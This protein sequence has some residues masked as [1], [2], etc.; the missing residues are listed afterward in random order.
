MLAVEFEKREGSLLTI[1]QKSRELIDI[2][3]SLVSLLVNDFLAA[4]LLDRN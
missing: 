1:W 4:D 2:L 3:S